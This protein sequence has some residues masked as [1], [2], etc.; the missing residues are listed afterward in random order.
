M[1]T[2][3]ISKIDD[4]SEL[5][6]E[7]ELTLAFAGNLCYENNNRILDTISRSLMRK[8][9][10][11]ILNLAEVLQIDSS[12]IRS[13]LQGRKLAERAGVKLRIGSASETV[14]RII[15]MSGLEGIFGWPKVITNTKGIPAPVIDLNKMTWKIYDYVAASDPAVISI[16][17]ENVKKAAIEAG[18]TGD[19]LCDIQIAAGEALSNAYKHGSPNKGV[20]KVYLRCM[21]CPKAIIIEV[22]DEGKPFD[23]NA[24]SEPDPN[25]MRD[26][27]MGIYLMRQAMDVVEFKSNF[28]GNKI[29]MVKW[30]GH[31]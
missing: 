31:R 4:L 5:D 15:G 25:Q 6:S 2:S 20:N 12:G 1:D 14:A 24:T 19:I 18:A 16:M 8:P 26:H 27:G 13:L 3:I 21:T 11:L 29:K 17:R 22:G 10:N 28:S 7:D 9:Q 23:P 30:L